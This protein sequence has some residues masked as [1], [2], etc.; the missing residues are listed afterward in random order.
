MQPGQD[1][2][3]Y[4]WYAMLGKNDIDLFEVAV[5]DL[6]RA[7][8][9]QSHNFVTLESGKTRRGPNKLE[10]LLHATGQQLSLVGF[11]KDINKHA[12]IFTTRSLT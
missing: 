6:A 5:D 2:S 4:K 9:Q 10:M 8:V 7:L 11:A 12:T 3:P 1:C